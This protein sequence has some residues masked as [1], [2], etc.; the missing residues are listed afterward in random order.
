[1]FQA[2]VLEIVDST[3]CTYNEGEKTAKAVLKADV[4]TNSCPR[5]CIPFSWQLS[6]D[7]L[8]GKKK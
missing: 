3:V 8:L 2:R 7:Y 6:S 1:V 5:H 4:R